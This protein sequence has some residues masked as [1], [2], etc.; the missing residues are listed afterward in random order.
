[1]RSLASGI[2]SRRRASPASLITPPGA[3]SSCDMS[4]RD[5]FSISP[6]AI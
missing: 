2:S 6:R 5:A 1:M 3:N 4:P